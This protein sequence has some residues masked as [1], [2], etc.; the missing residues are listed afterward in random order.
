MV[1]FRTQG[2][3]IWLGLTDLEAKGVWR[4]EDG[5]VLGWARWAPGVP[6]ASVTADGYC[7]VRSLFKDFLDYRC[8][9]PS[10]FVCEYDKGN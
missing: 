7:A 6:D 5:Y 9:D 2:V 4:W 1:Y 8:S 10:E 3:K